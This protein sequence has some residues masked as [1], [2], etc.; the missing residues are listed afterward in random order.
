MRDRVK[1]FLDVEENGRDLAVSGEEIVKSFLVRLMT[2]I[3]TIAIQTFL[4][5]VLSY[6]WSEDE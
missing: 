6:V 1:G 5:C 3:A 4:L 2:T